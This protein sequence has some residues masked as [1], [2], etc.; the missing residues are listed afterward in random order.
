MPCGDER[1]E[2]WDAPQLVRV[3]SIAAA[4]VL[5]GT[6]VENGLVSIDGG[7]F[8]QLAEAVYA[9]MEEQP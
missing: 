1:T 9:E 8:A 5:T 7:L 4:I 3:V 6:P 2:L